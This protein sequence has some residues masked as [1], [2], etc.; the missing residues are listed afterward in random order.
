[1]S[2][3]SK[4]FFGIGALLLTGAVMLG[5]FGT[6]SLQATLS[7]DRLDAFKTA[8]D[9]QM[10]HGLGLIVVAFALQWLPG[11]RLPGWAGWLMLFAIVCFSGSIYL[12]T[13]GAPPIVAMAAPVGGLSSM[14]AWVLLAVTA[15]RSA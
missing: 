9:F 8:V 14:I 1:M 2:S 7:A 6:H 5:A 10:H 4:M 3:Q 15:F 11:S 13:S 12:T